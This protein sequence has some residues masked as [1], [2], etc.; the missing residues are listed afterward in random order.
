MKHAGNDQARDEHLLALGVVSGDLIIMTHADKK[1]HHCPKR[2]IGQNE[3]HFL[4]E[5]D[6]AGIGID[7]HV[8]NVFDHPESDPDQS[9]EHD[10]VKDG[11][12]GDFPLF[13][14]VVHPFV[15]EKFNEKCLGN[16]DIQYDKKQ[17]KIVFKPGDKGQSENNHIDNRPY[18][19]PDE[20]IAHKHDGLL[21]GNISD[22]THAG[23]HGRRQN[24]DDDCEN[25]I[26]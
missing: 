19:R 5:I 24:N 15:F 4:K 9:A 23:Q 13:H 11:F 6:E 2:D 3:T 22:L 8:D 21:D 12:D 20:P 16:K 26:N 17:R 25:V 10:G 18:D 7:H 1:A 14:A